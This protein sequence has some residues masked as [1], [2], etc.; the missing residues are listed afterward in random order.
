MYDIY[1]QHIISTTRQGYDLALKSSVYFKDTEMKKILL[2][3]QS[4]TFF[5]PSWR[6]KIPS[7]VISLQ[8]E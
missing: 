1:T 6:F 7:G 2:Y 5:I 4:L 3:L 8:P